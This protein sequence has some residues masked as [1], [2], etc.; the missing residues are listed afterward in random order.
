MNAYMINKYMELD[1]R[2][3]IKSGKVDRF[4]EDI[5]RSTKTFDKKRDFLTGMI[6]RVTVKTEHR[7]NRKE[8][9]VQIGH[10]FVIRFKMKIV[11]DKLIWNDENDKRKGYNL[12]DGNNLLKTGLV[13]EVTAR[14]GRKF[15]KKS[16]KEDYE[17]KGKCNSLFELSQ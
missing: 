11:K 5:I 17:I 6:D 16:N 4:A 2:E 3:N 1:D 8:E 10:S 14:A 15:T 9:Q 12:K 13:H 7:F